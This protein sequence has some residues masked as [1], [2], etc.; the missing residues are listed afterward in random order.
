MGQ[1]TSHS[2]LTE[3]LFLGA[4]DPPNPVTSV[5]FLKLPGIKLGVCVC[6]CVCVCVL[7][8]MLCVFGVCVCTHTC[9]L[10]LS[11]NNELEAQCDACCR[12]SHH[13]HLGR[14]G[15]GDY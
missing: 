6:V 15:A 7:Y 3:W 12:R 1:E 2:G 4:L 9:C 5:L 8:C 14:A 11:G 13:G 10:S